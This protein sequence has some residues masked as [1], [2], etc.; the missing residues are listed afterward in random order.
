MEGSVKELAVYRYE[1]AKEDL[2]TA[3]MNHNN[4]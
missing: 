4:A 1:K 3:R 2:D